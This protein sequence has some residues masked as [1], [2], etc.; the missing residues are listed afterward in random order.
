LREC[1]VE[2][3]SDFRHLLVTLAA[4]S[5]FD[6]VFAIR[7]EMATA[8]ARELTSTANLVAQSQPALPH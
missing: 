8:I 6:V 7:L 1:A 2:C 4:E 5:G 3:A